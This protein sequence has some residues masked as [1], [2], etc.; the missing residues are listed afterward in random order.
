[1]FDILLSGSFE[2]DLGE[3]YVDVYGAR[4]PRGDDLAARETMTAAKKKAFEDTLM[5]AEPRVYMYCSH[6]VHPGIAGLNFNSFFH[7]CK[8]EDIQ[9]DMDKKQGP[10]FVLHDTIQSGLVGLMTIAVH[11]K[12]A[13]SF[14]VAALDFL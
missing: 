1:M 12:Q 5:H 4:D 8:L 9:F 10:A 11:R 13:I 2:P 6:L 14:M 7:M 3:Y